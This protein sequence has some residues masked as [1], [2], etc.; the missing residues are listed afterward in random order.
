MEKEYPEHRDKEL[1]DC[2]HEAIESGNKVWV[3]GDIHGYRKTLEALVS[4]LDLQE[5][6]ILICLGDMVDRGPDSVGVVELFMN[7]GNWYAL[8]GNH[9]EMMMIDW[10]KTNGF[11]NYSTNGFWSSE[12]PLSREKMLE[13]MGFMR[14]L[15]TE[16]VLDR[17]RLVHAGYADMPYST[18]LDEQTDEQRLWSRD[19][20]T[21]AYPLDPDRTIIVGHTIIQNYGFVDDADVYGTVGSN[22]SFHDRDAGWSITKGDYFVIN[23]EEI[24]CDTGN[25][26]FQLV[27]K[28]SN[29]VLAKIKLPISD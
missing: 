6:D 2:I 10:S 20:F 25:H 14:S 7:Q 5:N 23:C 4:R 17:F 1:E 3:I 13:I 18:S 26:I 11:G 15:P 29:T 12:K 8:L 19:V 22:V 27:D 28:G 16:I 21:V 9:E 24:E